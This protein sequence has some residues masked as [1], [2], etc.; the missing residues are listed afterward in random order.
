MKKN[1]SIA[2]IVLLGLAWYIT[3]ST[4]LGNETKYKNIVA[5][6]QRLEE[7]GLYLDAIAQYEMAKE[8]KG[9]ILFLDEAI[10]DDYLAMGDY[11]EYRKKMNGIIST[12]GPVEKDVVKLYDFT[13][14]NYSED[15]AIDL[16]NELY[17]RYPDSEI[18]RDYYDR[19]KGKYVERPCAFERIYD[20]TQEYAVYVQNGKKGLI[21]QDGKV[22]IEAV[23]DEIAYNGKDKGD[24]AVRDGKD[25]FFINQQGY[26]TKMPEETYEAVSALSQSR[27]VAKKDGKYGYLDKNFNAKTEFI[28]E[29]ATPFYE[30]VAAVKQGE[31]WALIDRKGELVTDFLFEEVSRNSR[32]ICSINK[33]IAVR[34]GKDFFFINEK[35][36]RLSEQTYE[37]VKTFEGDDMC[38]VRMK[39]KWGYVDKNGNLNIE[40]SYE[41]AKPFTNGYAAVKKNGI[42]GYID[43]NNNMTIQPV[44][45]DAGLMTQDGVAPVCHDTTWTLLQLKIM[46]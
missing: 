10:A 35:G 23:Y 6:A 34:Q 31:K 38:A 26:K 21:D 8:V 33:M 32:G 1:L 19:V 42:W 5:E 11:K 18:V 2:M 30:G 36:E 29:D 17:E 15:S 40:C 44:F 13:A 24:I 3:L 43:K 45:D 41:D 14:A 12:Y 25:C 37:E 27:I 4:W 28:Y 22:V 46:N 7:K 39:G 9:E 20:F 16:V